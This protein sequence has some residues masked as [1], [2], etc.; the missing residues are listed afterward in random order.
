MKTQEITIRVTEGAADLYRSAS[1]AKR[2]K[3]DALLSLRLSETSRPSPS[4]EQIMLEATKEAR[5]SGLSSEILD[6][7]LG[8]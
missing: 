3:L 5:E 4:I 6:A 7:I 2:R 8:E 1:E